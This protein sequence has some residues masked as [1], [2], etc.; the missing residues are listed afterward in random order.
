MAYIDP[1]HKIKVK[2]LTIRTDNAGDTAFEIISPATNT[3]V[4]T[5]TGAG[6]AT[7]AVTQTVNTVQ[8]ATNQHLALNTQTDSKQ[9]RIN[10]RNFTQT[11]GDSVGMQVTP[12]QA[13]TTTGEVYGAQF[14]PRVANTFNA[15]TCNGVGID[16]ELKGTGAGALTDDLRG[17]NMYL[18]ATGTGTIGGHIVGIRA[19]VESN[20]N[21]TGRIVLLQPVQHEGSQG[22][23]GLLEFTEALGTHSMTTSSDKTGSTKSGTIKVYANGTLYHIQLYANA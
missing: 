2:K 17:I 22:W 18:G 9:V 20:I 13:A 3:A 23:D 4:Y 14:K 8:A 12:N 1:K 16:S 15:L 10:S 11:T 6:A 5:S 7:T 21:P 19:R